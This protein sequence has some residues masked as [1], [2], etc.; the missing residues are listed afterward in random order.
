[1]KQLGDLENAERGR[2]VDEATKEVLPFMSDTYPVDVGSLLKCVVFRSKEHYFY[3]MC[4]T[5][6]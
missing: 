4:S 3:Y 5:C 2:F 6:G 1:M